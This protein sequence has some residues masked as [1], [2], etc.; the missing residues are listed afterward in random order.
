MPSTSAETEG[1]ARNRAVAWVTRTV[2]V[3]ALLPVALWWSSTRNFAG[4]TY[5]EQ[6]H[7][8]FCDGPGVERL[9]PLVL[10][11]ITAFATLVLCVVAAVAAPAAHR[12]PQRLVWAGMI[13]C[14]V[15]AANRANLPWAVVVTALAIVF[16]TFVT[17]E[18]RRSPRRER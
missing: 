7:L 16:V 8:A 5:C 9:A 13:G 11:P 6:H 18:A 3:I 10:W 17:D 2:A 15:F 12:R 4:A 1:A 14:V